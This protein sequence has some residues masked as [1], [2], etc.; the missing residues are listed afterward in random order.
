MKK[1]FLGTMVVAAAMF[2][3]YSAY[4]AQNKNEL[5]GITLAKIEALASLEG[6]DCHYSNGV[7]NIQLTPNFWHRTEYLYYD[8]CANEVKG[9]HFDEKCS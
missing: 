4:N 7:T 3:G 5:T 2:V 6:N 9:Y 1:N 8:C